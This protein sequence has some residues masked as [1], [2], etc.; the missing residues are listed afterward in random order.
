MLLKLTI[1]RD[2]DRHHQVSNADCSK[3][4]DHFISDN[5]FSIIEKSFSFMEQSS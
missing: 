4:L 2:P 5:N 1:G 3:K